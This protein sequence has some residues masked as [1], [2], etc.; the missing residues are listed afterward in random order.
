M[1]LSFVVHVVMLD[2]HSSDDGFMPPDWRM[3]LLSPGLKDFSRRTSGPSMY[4]R[5]ITLIKIMHHTNM[6]IT[7]AHEASS[8]WWQW[9]LAL[10]PGITYFSN[11]MALVLHPNPLV[12]YPAA[13][14]PVLC[15][16]LAVFGYLNGNV[17]WAGLSMWS[18]GYFASWLP[19]ALI[20]RVIFVYHYLVPLIFGVF[21]F[22]AS[23]DVALEKFPVAK[24][25]FFVVWFVA[26]MG[27]W[28]FFAPWC[29]AMTGFDWG[30]RTWNRWMFD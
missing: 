16:I 28:V 23:I 26:S 27:S 3:T 19:F 7:E 14:G 10:M 20:P 22:A 1:Y 4:N 30:I 2:Y 11:Q 17:R 12:W 6:G 29:Y 8:K 9:P 13:L 5:I 15:I 25:A 24:N 18:V 21:A